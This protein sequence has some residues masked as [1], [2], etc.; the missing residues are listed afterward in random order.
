M[1]HFDQCK[2]CNATVIVINHKHKLVQCQECDLIFCNEIF[3]NEFIQKT[4][5]ELYNKSTEYQMYQKQF[6]DLKKSKRLLLGWPRRKVFSNILNR[7]CKRICEIGAGVGVIGKYLSNKQNLSYTGIEMD[8][9]TAQKA[10]SLG[11]N[12]RTGSFTLLNEY[13]DHFDAI[14]AFEVIEHI[15]DLKEFLFLAHKSLNQGGRLGFS[16]PNYNKI[17]NYPK[18]NERLYQPSPP[19]HINFFT[20]DSVKKI[21]QRAGFVVRYI[22]IKGRPYFNYKKFDTYF[23]LFKAL[24]GKY[25]GPTIVCVVEKI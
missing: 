15:Q 2:I 7:P 25:Y 24:L 9:V 17:H 11:I 3:T 23:F 10:A 5:D 13:T 6:D 8:V 4:Y 12:V 1:E 22:D 18:G 16:V 20:K 19:I 21:F 14:V